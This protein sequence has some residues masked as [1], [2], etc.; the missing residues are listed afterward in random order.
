MALRYIIE[1]RHG[2]VLTNEGEFYPPESVALHYG[3][4]QFDTRED[5]ERYAMRTHEYTRIVENQRWI[6]YN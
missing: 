3:P 5:A 6:T 4:K 1:N 2:E